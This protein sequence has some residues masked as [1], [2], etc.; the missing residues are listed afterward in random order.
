MVVAAHAKLLGSRLHAA[1]H[2]QPVTRLEDVQRAADAG[3][4]HRAHEDGDVLGEAAARERRSR[5]GGRRGEDR[6]MNRRLCD[7]DYEFVCTQM[8]LGLFG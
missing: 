1:A 3:V 8:F 6:A 4:G 2:H 7:V 5:G